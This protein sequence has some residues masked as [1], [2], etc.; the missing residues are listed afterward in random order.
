M[1]VCVCACLCVCVYVCV[2]VCVARAGLSDCVSQSEL[3]ERQ[4]NALREAGPRSHMDADRRE[5]MC[6]TWGHAG[7]GDR[8]DRF[9]R[10]RLPEQRAGPR[11]GRAQER[12]WEH[13]SQ[14]PGTARRRGRRTDLTETVCCLGEERVVTDR[15]RHGRGVGPLCAGPG[16]GGP[17]T[18]GAAATPQT[19]QRRPRLPTRSGSRL[20]AARPGVSG[21][22]WLC[23]LQ[24]EDSAGLA[25]R[26]PT[27]GHGHPVRSRQR[28]SV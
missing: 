3:Q 13:A 22:A 9:T 25:H 20:Y 12:G 26:G 6:V 11:R 10:Q 17:G 24:G 7:S 15:Q 27:G 1:F 14:A 5:G 18:A 8:T 16:R 21:S 23:G 2:R 28:G 4:Q 19:G